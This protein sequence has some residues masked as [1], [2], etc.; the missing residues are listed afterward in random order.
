M[1]N[2]Y[3]TREDSYKTAKD[4]YNYV[5][6]IFYSKAPKDVMFRY[7]QGERG[8]AKNILNWIWTT[9]IEPKENRDV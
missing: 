6:H 4:I 1:G 2:E 7:N 5:Q 3:K 9:Y 8:I